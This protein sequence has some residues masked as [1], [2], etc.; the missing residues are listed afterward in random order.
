MLVACDSG[1]GDASVWNQVL[2]ASA[3]LSIR[4]ILAKHSS[5]DHN[6]STQPYSPVLAK[7]S[8]LDH[9]CSTQP[10]SPKNV[11]RLA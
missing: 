4:A 11:R 9:N 7:H 1:Q 6:C 10:Y 2:T 8:A 3:Y 5:L